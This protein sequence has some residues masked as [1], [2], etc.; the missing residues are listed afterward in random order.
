MAW[1]WSRGWC[2]SCCTSTGADADFAEWNYLVVVCG[3]GVAAALGARRKGSG[4]VVALIALGV[5]L[6]ASADVVWQ[7]YVSLRGFEPDVS[8]ADVAW[9]GSYVAIG[10]ALL[11][12][13]R[14]RGA[15]RLDLDG[16][17]DIA[18][19]TAVALLIQW[20]LVLK[21][22]VSDTSVAVVPR[23][24][25]ALYPALDAVLLAL[26]LRGVTARRL[27]GSLAVLVVRRGRLLAAVGLRLHAARSPPRRR[28]LWLDAG[29]MVGAMLLGAAAVGRPPAP[30]PTRRRRPRRSTWPMAGWSS[31]FVPL[32]ARRPRAWPASSRGPPR[33]G[34]PVHRG[35]RAGRHRLRPGHDSSAAGR[36]GV[37]AGCCPPGTPGQGRRRQLV[38]RGRR[39]RP[40]GRDHRRSPATGLARRPRRRRHPWVDLLDGR[41]RWT[42]TTPGAVFQR[43]SP[44]PARPSRP[45]CGCG[46]P[47][48]SIAW[49]GVRLVNLIDDPDV[50]GVVVNLHDITDRKRAEEELAHQA[51]HDGADRPAPTGRS[52]PTGS[53]RRCDRNARAGRDTAVLF[54]DLDGFKTVNDS[55]GH[56]AGDE[57]L[58]RGGPAPGRRRCRAGDTVARLG[59]DEFAVLVE[60]SRWPV[61]EAESV[62]ER[63]LRPALEPGRSSASS[64]VD[65]RRPASASPSATRDADAARRCCATPTSPCT[66]RRRRQGP[67]GRLRAGDAARRPSSGSSSR[68]TSSAPLDT[69]PARLVY[70]PVVELDDRARGRASRR[71]C[72]GT[73]RPSGVVAPDRFIP[74]AE[75]NG[76]IVP[77][78][79]LGAARRPAGR[80]PAGSAT[81]PTGSR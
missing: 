31:P 61:D 22:I 60:Q 52:S 11:L 14:G 2:S 18:A 12:L 67:V 65:R 25:W 56:G 6:S 13:L 16:V 73:T 4:K 55:L 46:T 39:A 79:A 80:R 57:L 21:D 1:R 51:F 64:R 41:R 44:C 26:V 33:P 29:W 35:G 34:P 75:E 17:I 28:H 62:A 7:G 58:Q 43:A 68:P 36:S 19:I 53:S 9:L 23:I 76:Q 45:S 74:L 48:G 54:L 30:A 63:I 71:C 50:G 10:F 37:R 72:A 77:I 47:T 40:D 20:N 15:R 66:G 81:Y 27:R 70:Q 78:G 49:L 69:R 38:R 8:V 24:V 3:A 32:L 5:C 42:S 59:G